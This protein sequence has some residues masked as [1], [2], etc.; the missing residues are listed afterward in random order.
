MLIYK[1]VVKKYQKI[2]NWCNL[3]KT[4]D[5]NNAPFPLADEAG[6]L[7]R[8]HHSRLVCGRLALALIHPGCLRCHGRM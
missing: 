6:N 2:T 3:R 4:N 8:R 7:E 1:Y 5:L